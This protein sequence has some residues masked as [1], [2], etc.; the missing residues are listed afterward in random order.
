MK[1][2]QVDVAVLILFFNNPDRLAQ[3]FSQV[4]KARPSK[5]FLYQDGPRFGRNDEPGIQAC[6]VLVENIDWECEV[7]RWYQEK[8]VGCDPSEFLSQKWAFSYVDKCVILEDDDVP[9]VSFFS[10]CKELLDRYEFD[11][12]IGM[13]AGMNHEEVTREVSADYFFTTNVSIWG[14]A[15]WK[16]VADQWDEQYS[17]TKNVEIMKQL[18]AKLKDMRYRR[19]FLPL[20]ERHAGKGI[21]YYETI[22]MS[23]MLL[24]NSLS[25][26][27]TRNMITNI[28]MAGGTHSFT[29]FDLLPPNMKKL[30]TLKRYELDKI[31]KHPESVIEN[32]GFKDRVYWMMGW[33]HPVVQLLRDI[34]RKLLSVFAQFTKIAR[35]EKCQK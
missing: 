20:L 19:D 21:P 1:T 29:E 31:G 8:N 33:N 25:I 11:E 27:P 23:Y 30:Y 2:A 34:Y 6:R 5:L 24:S 22:H 14:W 12:R 35:K 26:V 7:H 32:V 13:I 9:A 3:V 18:T 28:G 15:T 17:F 4:Q 16:R 10:F